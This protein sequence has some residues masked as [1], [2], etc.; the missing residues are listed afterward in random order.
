V[1][2]NA[3]E[4]YWTVRLGAVVIQRWQDGDEWPH[5]TLDSRKLRL[6]DGAMV[7]VVKGKIAK[8]EGA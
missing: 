2:V 1:A 3:P 7:H 4:F 5:A 6:K 8:C